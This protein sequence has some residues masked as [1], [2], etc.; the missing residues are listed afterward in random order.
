MKRRYFF[1]LLFAPLLAPFLTKRTNPYWENG[2]EVLDV[3]PGAP[4]AS[5]YL[6]LGDALIRAGRVQEANDHFE[7]MKSRNAN[8]P[9]SHFGFFI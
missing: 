9:E 5:T 3:T 7:A 1:A 2:W 6:A 8:W 4:K